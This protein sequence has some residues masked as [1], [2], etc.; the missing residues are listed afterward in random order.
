[1]ANVT[2]VSGTRKTFAAQLASAVAALDPGALQV[3]QL[4]INQHSG[5]IVAFLI[6]P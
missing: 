4:P 2:A 3:I 1:M 5:E 6:H